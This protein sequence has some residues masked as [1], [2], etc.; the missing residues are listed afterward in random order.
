VAYF[1]IDET[2]RVRALP[3]QF[4]NLFTENGA[5]AQGVTRQPTVPEPL[6]LYVLRNLD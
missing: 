3:M 4:D 6:E 5:P 1:T 2:G